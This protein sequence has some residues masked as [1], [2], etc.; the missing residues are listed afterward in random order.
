MDAEL[1]TRALVRQLLDSQRFAVL[2]T[3][4]ES[5][6]Y[7]SLVA[8]WAAGDLSHVLFATMRD[9]RKFSNLTA[10]PQVALLFD[11]RSNRDSDIQEGM[12]VT[13]TGEAWELTDG[14]ARTA[15]AALFLAKHPQLAEFVGSPGCAL[16]RVEVDVYHVVTHF[17]NVVQLFSS[18]TGRMPMPSV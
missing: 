1:E 14:G 17:Q 4:S 7:C 5:G 11:D 6:P 10:H 3:A 16:V 18:P 12:A 2:S 8:F 13:A 9:S 15:A